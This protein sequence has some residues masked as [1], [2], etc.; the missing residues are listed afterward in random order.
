[1]GHSSSVRFPR[2]RSL[3]SGPK[4][5]RGFIFR[6]V[7]RLYFARSEPAARCLL[8]FTQQ[9]IEG[10]QNHSSPAGIFF[11]KKSMALACYSPPCVKRPS[12]ITIGLEYEPR[13]SFTTIM[14]F[15]SDIEPDLLVQ[16]LAEAA[17]RPEASAACGITSGGPCI[18]PLPCLSI[19]TTR[20]KL[21]HC[22]D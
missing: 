22:S 5:V 14:V 8:A 7:D 2:P 10:G 13:I 20:P 4:T 6:L 15:S 9:N 18:H 1:L 17:S 19:L 21:R 3:H 16:R 11:L 12:P